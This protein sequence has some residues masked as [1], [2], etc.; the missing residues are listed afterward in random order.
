MAVFA[1]R[2][3]P[4]SYEGENM[5][6]ARPA[7][8][9]GVGVP[10]SSPTLE[11]RR[12]WER[13]QKTRLAIADTIVI[14]VAVAWGL[15]VQQP[16]RA[17]LAVQVLQALIFAVLLMVSLSALRSRDTEALGS[18]IAEYRRVMHAGGVGLSVFAVVGLLFDWDGLRVMLFAVGPVIIPGLLLQRCLMRRW[19][20]RQRLRGRYV[21][22][23][24]VVGFENDVR[25]VIESLRDELDNGFQVVGATIFDDPRSGSARSDEITGLWVGENHYSVLGTVD[26]VSST[27]AVLGADRIVVASTPLD[28]PEFVRR[29]SWELE[30]AAAELVLS[31]QIADIAGPRLSFQPLDGL[32]LLQ[33]KIPTYEGGKHLLK[34]MFDVIVAIVALIPIGLIITPVLAILIKLDSPG[35]VFYRQERIGRDGRR[36]IH[37]EVP[38]HAGGRRRRSG[39]PAG[40]ERRRGPAVQ[41]EIRSARHPS[42]QGA[43]SVLAR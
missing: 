1:R 38:H 41:A 29:L 22:R 14:A 25:Y 17:T 33:I 16:H 43:A 5:L 31:Y 34:W 39:G 40:A 37:D 23:T 2:T 3:W 20:R 18:G 42:R 19:L 9:V 30:G 26:S 8:D 24:L 21:S 12:R 36:L 7:A 10:Q 27:A 32:P 13:R 4:C 15:V 28:R 35:P 11:R 6:Q